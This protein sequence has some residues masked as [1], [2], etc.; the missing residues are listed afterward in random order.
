M[1]S[2][3]V[4]PSGD[5][6]PKLYSDPF[7]RRE[8]NKFKLS[9]RTKGKHTPDDIKRLLKAKINPTEINV[10]ILDLKTLRDGRILI[11]AGSKKE[12]ETLGAKIQESCGEELEIDIQKLR[13]P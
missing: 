1:T 13:N 11:E 5:N 6:Y 12:T 4:L 3:Q 10:G 7:V 9:L 8:G 2:R